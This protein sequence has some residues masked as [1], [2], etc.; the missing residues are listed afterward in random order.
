[1]IDYTTGEIY[2]IIAP[3]GKRYIGQ[4]QSWIGIKQHK[5]HGTEKRWKQHINDANS[6]S[7]LL[8]HRAI[9]KYGDKTFIVKTIK[10]CPIWQLNYYEYKYIRQYKTLHPNGYNMSVG[11]NV[12]RFCE[13]VR[14]KISIANSGEKNHFYG[15]HWSE[16]Q[17]TKMITSISQLPRVS[18]NSK[19]P[20][21][22]CYYKRYYT[23]KNSVKFKEGYNVQNHPTLKRKTFCSMKISME[24]KL[25]HALK[26][27]NQ[28]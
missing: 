20:M 1:M 21:Y 7:N 14:Q 13:E 10:I 27:L 23:N 25:N 24:E 4:C 8:F 15:K 9:R 5:K 22:I 26:Y 17:K 28:L 3:N 11:G 12:N 6:K 2:M 18:H 19:L 16:E